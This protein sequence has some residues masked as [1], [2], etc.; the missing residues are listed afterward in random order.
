MSYHKSTSGIVR[1]QA[2][3]ATAAA[4][5]G[6]FSLSEQKDEYLLA[7]GVR[8]SVIERRNLLLVFGL[9]CIVSHSSH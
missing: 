8:G 1:Q 9:G 7:V 2:W 3:T 5:A 6:V 4:S